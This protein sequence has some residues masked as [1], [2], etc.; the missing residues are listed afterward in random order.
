MKLFSIYKTRL[1]QR[2]SPAVF[3]AM[4]L[5][6]L[7]VSAA[8]L[9]VGEYGH[10]VAGMSNSRICCI[11]RCK[12]NAINAG[13]EKRERFGYRLHEGLLCWLLNDFCV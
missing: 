8:F 13:E 6:L 10:C 2:S 4:K 11:P 1:F 5:V 3:N 9:S 7:M 12:L